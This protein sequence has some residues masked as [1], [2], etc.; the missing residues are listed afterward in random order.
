VP[1]S[2]AHEPTCVA[3]HFRPTGGQKAGRSFSESVSTHPKRRSV[4]H[5]IQPFQKTPTGEGQEGWIKLIP[6]ILF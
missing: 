1:L 4:K 6:L 5:K 3:S 2:V